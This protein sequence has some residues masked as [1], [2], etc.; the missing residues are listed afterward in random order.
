MTIS[1]LEVFVDVSVAIIVLKITGLEFRLRSLADEPLITETIE[2]PRART[3]PL[4]GVA[5]CC[6][7]LLHLIDKAVAVII[8]AVTHLLGGFIRRAWTPAGVAIADLLAQT[9][10][11]AVGDLTWSTDPFCGAIAAARARA[12]FTQCPCVRDHTCK[13]ISA[14]TIIIAWLQADVGSIQ[15]DAAPLETCIVISTRLTR[16]LRGDRTL[17]VIQRDVALIALADHAERRVRAPSA[18]RS[19]IRDLA[20]ACISACPAMVIERPKPICVSE[21]LIH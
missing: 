10:P 15:A 9:H 13:A 19:A 17:K 2:G 6:P 5:A 4:Y 20:V 1:I 3:H 7:D 11:D 18:D 21:V 16:H 12:R 8:D 14:G